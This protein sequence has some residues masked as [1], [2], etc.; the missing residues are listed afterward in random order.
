MSAQDTPQDEKAKALAEIAGQMVRYDISFPELARA[1]ESVKPGVAGRGGK[2]VL[3]DVAARLFSTL[4]GIFIF[5]GIG[6][7]ISMFWDEMNSVMRIIATLGIGLMMHAL[8]IQALRREIYVRT[9]KPLLL[10]SAFLQ[11]TGWFVVLDEFLPRGNDERYAILFVMAVMFI[12]QGSAFLKHRLT[13]LLF[14]TLFFGY[15]FVAVCLDLLHADEKLSMIG[16]GISMIAIAQAI[17]P[18]PHGV[19]SALGDLIGAMLLCVGLFNLVEHTVFEIVY[20]GVVCGLIYVSTLVRS[21]ALLIASTIAMLTYIAYFTSEHFVD[22]VGWPL[23][24]VVLGMI[25]FGV[26]TF[27]LRVKRRYIG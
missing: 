18:T 15:S 7:Y 8:I 16:F 23:S 6:V 21:T 5:S 2:P 12:Q 10:I 19:I 1:M 9:V 25:F 17:R 20:L 4:G 22:S 11:T 27:M 13:L 14:G 26:S 24:L 3:G